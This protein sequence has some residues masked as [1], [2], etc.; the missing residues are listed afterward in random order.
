MPCL[1]HEGFCLKGVEPELVKTHLV[2]YLDVKESPA[3]DGWPQSASNS[4]PEA[5]LGVW[6]GF[7]NPDTNDYKES[8]KTDFNSLL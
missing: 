2:G 4:P 3:D 6:I 7:Q 8:K 1:H 5:N